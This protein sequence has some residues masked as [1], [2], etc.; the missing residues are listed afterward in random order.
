MPTAQKTGTTA[1]LLQQLLSNLIII[2]V[3]L[4]AV[5][6]WAIGI[7]LQ[8][9][10][11]KEN[12][13]AISE[14]SARRAEQE[15]RQLILENKSHPT[16]SELNAQVQK[17]IQEKLEQLGY[18]VEVQE[19]WS[20]GTS[21]TCAQVHNILAHQ[22]GRETNQAVLLVAHYDSAGASPGASDNAAS[23][24]AILE[25]ARNLE[26][27]QPLRNSVIF[28]MSDGEELG[29]L[30]AKAFMDEHPWATEIR[31]VINL[32]ARGTS[33]RSLVFETSGDNRWLID[34][35]ATSVADPAASS[36]FP[37]I[38]RYL[39]NDTDLSIFKR[40]GIAGLNQAFVDN[41]H[42]Y[43]TPQDDLNHLELGSLQHQG[44]TVLA[45]TR[46][47]ADMDLTL[48]RPGKAVYIDILGF[49]LLWWPEAWAGPLALLPLG[50]LAALSLQLIRQHQLTV[51]A[52]G[53]GCLAWLLGGLVPV[54]L[55]TALM[56][57]LRTATGVAYPW[58]AYPLP[59]RAMIW[60]GV[61]FSNGLISLFFFR[62]TGH[63]GLSLGSW[64]GWACLLVIA[65]WQAPGSSPLFWIPLSVAMAALAIT[66]FWPRFSRFALGLAYLVSALGAGLFGMQLALLVESTLG[67]DM[68]FIISIPLAL[69]ASALSPLWVFPNTRGWGKKLLLA[70]S[71]GVMLLTCMT[72]MWLP[73]YSQTR[74]QLVNIR[75]VQDRNLSASY[76]IIRPLDDVIPPTMR[77]ASSLDY[78]ALFPWSERKYWVAPAPH[79]PL[80]TPALIKLDEKLIGAERVANV[81]LTPLRSDDQTFLYIPKQA[82]LGSI[83]VEG[84][85]IPVRRDN[86][87]Y[88]YVM[89]TGLPPTGLEFELHFHG[90]NPV[91]ILV[92]NTS[93]GLPVNLK[94]EPLRPV[95]AI[96]YQNGD[97]TTIL[98][99]VEF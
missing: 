97:T 14:F 31:V 76:W 53:G 60:S 90:T 74:P 65:I 55:S 21:G 56:W 9:P 87:R 50:I 81:R 44:E 93:L 95:S 20:C 54:L 61:L 12:P 67:A 98:F 28:F 4:L 59:T 49:F 51:S 71:V 5:L 52:L 8:P 43:H 13:M 17:R 36:L 26:A 62:K 1:G 29:S 85:T 68:R 35:Y 91:E 89:F 25:I 48:P 16:G 37:E 39:P 77:A 78:L 86:S 72:A 94:G 79:T 40:E 66:C 45:L 70:T 73:P 99:R 75:Y 41:S 58:Y 92:S 42:Y 80:A 84:K 15:L 27:A 2:T 18:P 82:L 47:F 32:E 64:C 69:A 34:T 23:V 7:R 19:A 11:L 22:V 6:A 24:A 3:G 96:P 63:W 88:D 33:G 46:R 10:P 30:G 38:Y 57:V 83:V